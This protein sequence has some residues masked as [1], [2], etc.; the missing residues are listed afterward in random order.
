M[1]VRER[2]KTE[3]IFFLIFILHSDQFKPKSYLK[4]NKKYAFSE[5][6][7]F[8]LKSL[9]FKTM[10]FMYIINV[11]L[12]DVVVEYTTDCRRLVDPS[13]KCRVSGGHPGNPDDLDS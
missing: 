7:Q 2:L 12:C 5:G 11:K 8:P 1:R 3:I 6:E 13:H 4:L 10:L 9:C